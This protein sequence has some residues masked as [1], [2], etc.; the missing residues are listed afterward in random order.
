MKRFTT[1]VLALALLV[2]ACASAL[3]GQ[4]YATFIE[5]YDANVTFI[6]QNDNRHLLPLLLSERKS[7]QNDMTRIYRDLARVSLF[8]TESEF[9][10]FRRRKSESLLNERK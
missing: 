3:T 6:N 1:L 2:P 7:T 10:Q 9:Q 8:R 5:N 4:S